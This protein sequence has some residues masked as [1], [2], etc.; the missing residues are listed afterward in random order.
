MHGYRDGEDAK[1]KTTRPVRTAHHRILIEGDGTVMTGIS[2]SE[3]PSIP[4]FHD[5][6]LI[7]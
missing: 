5:K 6:N 3:K 4:E 2:R 1:R 7:S